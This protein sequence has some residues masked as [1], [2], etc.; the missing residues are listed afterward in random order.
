MFLVFF[1]LTTSS[2]SFFL[3]IQASTP[4]FYDDDIPLLYLGADTPA[5]Y[6]DDD[7]DLPMGLYYGL[8]AGLRHALRRRFE[9]LLPAGHEFVALDAAGV[10]GSK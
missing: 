2:S 5:I 3:L 9:A 8:A 4:E 1:F 7:A 10:A 6:L